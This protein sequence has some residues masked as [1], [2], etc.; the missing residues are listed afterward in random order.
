MSENILMIIAHFR[1]AGGGG[2]GAT[3]LYT[4]TESERCGN[5]D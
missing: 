5:V 4:M 1:D 3:L 2:G